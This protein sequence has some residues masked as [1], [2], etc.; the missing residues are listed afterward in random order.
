[1]VLKCEL[2]AKSQHMVSYVFT[3]VVYFLCFIKHNKSKRCAETGYSLIWVAHNV[4]N[5]LHVDAAF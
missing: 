4:K 5:G 3:V 1:M 2:V